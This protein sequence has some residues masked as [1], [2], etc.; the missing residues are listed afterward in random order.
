MF[1]IFVLFDC[2]S[3]STMPPKGVEEA[4]TRFYTCII[5]YLNCGIYF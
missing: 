1:S 2:L 5:A 4:G 3:N